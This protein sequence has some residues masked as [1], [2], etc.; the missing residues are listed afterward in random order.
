MNLDTVESC[1]NGPLGSG[2]KLCSGGVDLLNGHGP[3]RVLGAAGTV[4]VV[5]LHGLRGRAERD[6]AVEHAGAGRTPG[7]PDLVEDEAALGVDGVGHGFPAGDLGVCEDARG[8]GVGRGIEADVRGLGELQS[9]LGG[10][11]AV[12]LYGAADGDVNSMALLLGSH[13]SEGGLGYNQYTVWF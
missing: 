8:A 9:A 6:L 1:R 10:P 2:G 11:L 13:A 3:G 5:A 12:V 4:E 7:V